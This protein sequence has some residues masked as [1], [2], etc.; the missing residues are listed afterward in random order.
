MVREA[1]F[2]C[3]LRL[4]RTT[5][6]NWP[7]R[8]SALMCR[9]L[10]PGFVVISHFQLPLL[11]KQ[12]GTRVSSLQSNS[13]LIFH[14]GPKM[15]EI[16]TNWK[17]IGL[18]RFRCNRLLPATTFGEKI[19]NSCELPAKQQQL[20]FS[21]RAINVGNG[22]KLAKIWSEEENGKGGSLRSPAPPSADYGS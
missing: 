14:R 16:T 1:H 13:N 15:W 3:Q 18:K 5:D 10:L 6:H 11:E 4:T 8:L 20:H 2:V 22:N 12:S 7:Y 19:R 9:L 21:Q 17:K